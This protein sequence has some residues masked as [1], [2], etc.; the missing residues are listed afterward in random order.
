MEFQLMAS[1]MCTDYGNLEQEGRELEAG[2]INSFQSG[3]AH[4][5]K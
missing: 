2:G 1:M 3:S 4:D 5:E